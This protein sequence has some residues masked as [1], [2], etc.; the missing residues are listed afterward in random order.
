MGIKKEG[1]TATIESNPL[2][3]LTLCHAG[4][5]TEHFRVR[6]EKYLLQS[7]K[8]IDV[9]DIEGKG[10]RNPYPISFVERFGHDVLI[11]C[12]ETIKTKQTWCFLQRDE[13]GAFIQ[14]H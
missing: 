7:L 9:R 2:E 14:Q 12:D 10:P 6:L 5:V 1:K 11:V 3:W 13:M 8:V 4:M